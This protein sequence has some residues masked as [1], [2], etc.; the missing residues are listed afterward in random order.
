MTIVVPT[1]SFMDLNEP[2][3]VHEK[4]AEEEACCL[5]LFPNITFE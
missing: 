2:R 3:K 1:D 4:V 5:G